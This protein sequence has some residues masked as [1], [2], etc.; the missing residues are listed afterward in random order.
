MSKNPDLLDEVL[1]EEEQSFQL[2]N[3]LKLKSCKNTFPNRKEL[4]YSLK[5]E[6]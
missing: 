5:G 6:R 4:E 1:L 3:I 2:E